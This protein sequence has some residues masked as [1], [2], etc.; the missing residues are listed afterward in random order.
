MLK[1]EEL[2]L[3][4]S[5]EYASGV[6]EL[7]AAAGWLEEERPDAGI[8]LL[9]KALKNSYCAYGAY[10][11]GKLVGFVRA[12]SD[13]VGD[14][15]IIDFTVAPDFCRQGIGTKLADAI[16]GRLR[17]DGIAWITAIAEKDSQGIFLKIGVP[18][19][20]CLPVRF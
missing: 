18:M 16:V 2:N 4:E 6:A 3:K 5:A 15:F 8:K 20:D 11:D 12:L 1:I 10:K 13:G 17:S 7:Y 14:A 19:K 9:N